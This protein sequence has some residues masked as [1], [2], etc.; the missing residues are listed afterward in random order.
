MP[1]TTRIRL[2]NGRF[3]SSGGMFTSNTLDKGL[4]QFEF[5]M[6]EG[7]QQF[8]REFAQLWEDYAKQTAPWDDRTGDARAG[9]TAEYYED[10]GRAV[11]VVLYHTVDYGIWLEVRWGSKYAVILPSMEKMGPK[12]L[13]L[14][15]GMMDRI[16]FYE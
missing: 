7:I 4:A 9:L 15:E 8:A 5:K 1:P 16:I 2:G 12:L 10:G 13:N 11:G 14:M 3:G 6:R